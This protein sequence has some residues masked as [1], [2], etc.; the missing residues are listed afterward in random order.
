MTWTLDALD[1][2]TTLLTV[3]NRLAIELRARHDRNQVAAGRTVWPSADILPWNAWLQRL[4]QQLLDEGFT[5]LDLLSPA[6]ERLLWEQV[7]RQQDRKSGL[8]RPAAAAEAAQSAYALYTAWQ[9]RD[10]PL[11]SLGSDETRRFLAWAQAF[12][13]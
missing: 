12:E 11:G 3:N 10:H 9:L 13:D 8:L 1:P 5:A 6:Q 2:G 7:I 4:Y